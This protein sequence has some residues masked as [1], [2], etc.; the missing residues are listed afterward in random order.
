MGSTL[1]GLGG[2]RESVD[3]APAAAGARR[4][5][6]QAGARHLRSLRACL[7]TELPEAVASSR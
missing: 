5:A 1:A 3:G 7:A 4:C 2:V 6:V